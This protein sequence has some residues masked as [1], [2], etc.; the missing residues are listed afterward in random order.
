MSMM[1]RPEEEGERTRLETLGRS[2]SL[3]STVSSVDRGFTFGGNSANW[4]TASLT[5]SCKPERDQ[6]L[7]PS[8]PKRA[9]RIRTSIH[10][11]YDSQ[12][13]IGAIPLE[14]RRTAPMPWGGIIFMMNTRRDEICTAN[15]GLQ[16]ENA[17]KF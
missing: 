12:E 5:H 8:S 4:L 15:P 16:F 2:A 10:H 6:H 13:G 11:V 17:I 14:M 7:L 3:I 9:N 1:A